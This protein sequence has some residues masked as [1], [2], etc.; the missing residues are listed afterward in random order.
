VRKLIRMLVASAHAAGRPVGICGQ[1]PSDRPDFVR[2]LV[3]AGIDS[4]SLNPDSM[5]KV[6]RQVAEAEG[7]DPRAGLSEPSGENGSQSPSA[8]SERRTIG[9][10]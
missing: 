3:Q 5:L 1:A 8:E 2:F 7:D 10:P 6:I 9:R 4:I